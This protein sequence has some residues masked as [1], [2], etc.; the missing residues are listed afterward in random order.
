[1]SSNQIDI[2]NLSKEYTDTVGYRINLLKNVNF[3][4]VQGSVTTIVAPTGSGKS[5]LLK[6]VGGLEEKS[7]GTIGYGGETN[8]I[9][10]PS[11]PSSFPWFNVKQNISFGL[12]KVDQTKVSDLIKLVG[13]E[14]YEEHVPHNKSIGFRFRISLATALIRSP[15]MIILDEPFNDMD[16]ATKGEIYLLIKNVNKKLGITF[17]LGTT[18]ISEAIFLSDK[19][20]LMKKNPGEIIDEIKINLGDTNSLEVL[21]TDEFVEVRRKIENLFKSNQTQK[22]F[23]FSI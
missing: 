22:L 5:S 4:I 20:F 1:M 16:S 18:N 11:K 9:Y 7:S 3:S 13:L 2:V 15:H 14:G 19:I 6:I 8:N 21:D 10:I 17:L 23:T 12:K